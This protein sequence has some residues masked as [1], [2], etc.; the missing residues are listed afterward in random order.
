MGSYLQ[1]SGILAKRERLCDAMVPE[2]I[3]HSHD[4]C[5]AKQ[6][7]GTIP[8]KSF[9]HGRVVNEKLRLH[10]QSVPDAPDMSDGDAIARARRVHRP[11]RPPSRHHVIPGADQSFYI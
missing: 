8:P 6:G 11:V 7:S 3:N 1:A 2:R 9:Q 4:R 10:H 5:G